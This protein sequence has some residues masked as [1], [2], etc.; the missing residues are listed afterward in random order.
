MRCPIISTPAAPQ[1]QEPSHCRYRP[2]VAGRR[3]ACAQ[4]T[5]GRQKRRPRD[6]R[7]QVDD[8]VL[9]TQRPG[10]GWADQPPVHSLP[11]DA[12]EPGA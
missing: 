2:Q 5:G 12:L 7:L 10:T 11:L 1:T 6:G 8:V 9:E 4:R 3:L